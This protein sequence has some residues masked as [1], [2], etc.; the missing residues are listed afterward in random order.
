MPNWNDVLQEITS[1]ARANPGGQGLDLIRRKYLARL[2]AHTGRTTI[3]YYSAFLSKDDA[4]VFIND[5]DIN[6]LMLC[7]HGVDKNAG[8]D[9][10][11]HTP[12]G[13]IAA[14]ESFIHY[15]K[16]IFGNDLRAIVPQIA[17]SGGSIIA[18]SCKS[19]VMGKHSNIGPCD[20]QVRGFPALAVKQ[21]FKEMYDAIMADSAAADAYGPLLRQLGPS[22]LK[23]CDQAIDWADDFLRQSLEDNMFAGDADAASKARDATNQLTSDNKRGHDKHFYIDDCRRMNLTVEVLE[24]DKT[25]QDLVLTVHH[26][27]MHTLANTAALKVVENHK[28]QALIKN[29][30]S[31]FGL[32]LFNLGGPAPGGGKARNP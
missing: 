23:E 2:A 14:T 1:S 6:G 24:T 7:S 28:G 21:Q 31:G 10:L 15:V 32:P 25:L 17:M 9:L 4:S 5:D 8:L 22:F 16:S 19:I 30:T 18:C 29:Q 11:L 27:F 13:S 20:P 3:A 26:C 12:G